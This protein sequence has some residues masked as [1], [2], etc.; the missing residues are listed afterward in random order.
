MDR[1]KNRKIIVPYKKFI[2][3]RVKLFTVNNFDIEI[4]YDNKEQIRIN[5]EEVPWLN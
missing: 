2:R 4:P 1:S 3:L 5:T